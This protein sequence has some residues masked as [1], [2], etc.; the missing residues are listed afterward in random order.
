MYSCSSKCLAMDAHAEVDRDSFRGERRAA[1]PLDGAI[2]VRGAPG[3]DGAGGELIT[4]GVAGADE[5]QGGAAMG[6]HGA[7]LA[8]GG[9]GCEREPPAGILR[10]AMAGSEPARSD[11][12]AW[13]GGL[14]IALTTFCSCWRWC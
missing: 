8:E 6:G 9:R 4:R 12:A 10:G 13:A 2:R 5:Q 3:A 1:E 14:V 7:F 11:A